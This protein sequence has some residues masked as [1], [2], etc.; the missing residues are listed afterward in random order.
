MQATLLAKR[1]CS[2]TTSS[3][4]PSL[5]LWHETSEPR[6]LA[7]LHTR[8]PSGSRHQRQRRRNSPA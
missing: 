7:G 2:L 8:T 3:V 1:G 5:Q 6:P 4:L